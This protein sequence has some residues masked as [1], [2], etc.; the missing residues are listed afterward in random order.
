MIEPCNN[1]KKQKTCSVYEFLTRNKERKTPWV[2]ADAIRGMKIEP[3]EL[4]T[5]NKQEDYYLL[6]CSDL[7][8]IKKQLDYSG[9]RGRYKEED[10]DVCERKTKCSGNCKGECK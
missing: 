10:F 9:L 5:V 4:V 2:L 3:A 8:P 7:Q 1:C 6:E